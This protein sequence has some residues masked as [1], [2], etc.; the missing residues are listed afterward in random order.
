MWRKT[1]NL[2][3]PKLHH[4]KFGS[5][6]NAFQSELRMFGDKPGVPR[7]KE[8]WE[9]MYFIFIGGGFLFTGIALAFK[10][11]TNIETWA[12]IEA[13]KRNEMIENGE[14]I[15]VGVTYAPALQEKKWE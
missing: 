12:T 3:K 15:E 13:K 11:D 4:R 9:N 2:L 8:S 7:K 10:K 14:K 1:I 6:P 5:D